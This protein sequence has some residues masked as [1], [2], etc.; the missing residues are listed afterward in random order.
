[1]ISTKA[2]TSK[3]IESMLDDFGIEIAYPL[4]LIVEEVDKIRK[5]IPKSYDMVASILAMARPIVE[6]VLLEI[7]C[8]DNIAP[9]TGRGRR[10]IP[11]ATMMLVVILS[12]IRSLG[13]YRETE[14]ALNNHPAW[15]K[16]LGLKRAPHHSTMGKFCNRK[17]PEFFRRFFYKMTGLLMAFGLISERDA[18]IIDSAPVEANMNFA[19]ANTEPSLNVERLR[20]FFNSIDFSR[21]RLGA[22][23]RPSRKKKYDNLSLFRFL[24]FEHA[25]GFLSRSQALRYLEKHPEVASILG[26]PGGMIPCQATISNFERSV[27]RLGFLMRPLVDDIVDFFDSQDDYDENEPLAFFFWDFQDRCTSA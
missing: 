13:S 26:F 7:G 6:V 14:R 5:R 17:G 25:C 1:M 19:R 12:K 8:F 21:V 2:P 22:F 3:M 16:A 23:D 9:V 10:A 18:A 4:G 15:L 27:P 11:T 20:S 24:V